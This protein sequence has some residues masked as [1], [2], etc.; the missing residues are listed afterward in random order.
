MIF[1]Q[2]QQLKSIAKKPRAQ[3]ITAL[4]V[5]CILG[6]QTNQS[7]TRPYIANVYYEV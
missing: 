1:L 7:T 3:T 5:F 6:I 4:I 2:I